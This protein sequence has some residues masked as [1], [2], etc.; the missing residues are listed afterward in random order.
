[1]SHIALT[2][3]T[4]RANKK[5]VTG[6]WSAIIVQAIPA[7]LTTT[8]IHIQRTNQE[9]NSIILNVGDAM[10]TNI[11]LIIAVVKPK[12]VHSVKTDNHE[13]SGSMTRV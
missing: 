5:S 13:I 1:M 7:V 4:I 9:M 3:N 8:M 11:P 6:I 12:H 2:D 10:T